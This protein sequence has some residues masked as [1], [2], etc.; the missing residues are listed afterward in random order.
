MPMKPPRICGCGFK[1]AANVACEC[2]IKRARE[3]KA[4]H[5]ARRPTAGA[6]GY[7]QAW[8]TYRI[9]FLRKHP[10]CERPGCNAP[11]NIVDHKIPHR[12]DS[13]LF[14]DKGNHQALCTHCHTSWKQGQEKR[15]S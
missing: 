8:R 1:V 15:A 13:K 7:N 2:Q 12:G 14:W 3:A 11:A 4:R 10:V 6:R 5:D 9:A